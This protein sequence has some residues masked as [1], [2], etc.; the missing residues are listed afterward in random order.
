MAQ[1]DG[2]VP[3]VSAR[4]DALE[5]ENLLLKC[6]VL[7]LYRSRR[8]TRL[9]LWAIVLTAVGHLGASQFFV[10]PWQQVAHFDRVTAN[11]FEV[12][13]RISSEYEFY[14]NTHDRPDAVFGWV[15]PGELEYGQ[16]GGRGAE[17]A[18]VRRGDGPGLYIRTP[19]P[20]NEQQKEEI[21]LGV[22]PGKVSVPG[23]N[24]YFR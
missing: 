21:R 13:N 11:R 4:L 2:V 17:Q 19:Q 6:Q 24:R 23:V 18:Q 14:H 8:R 22:L 16:W 9:V 10:L 15:S 20:Q 12:P 3:D 5:R 7:D 1:S